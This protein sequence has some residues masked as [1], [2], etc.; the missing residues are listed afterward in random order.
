MRLV[1]E[2]LI[3]LNALLNLA[4]VSERIF[5]YQGKTGQRSGR[6]TQR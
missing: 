6:H 1:T 3:C 2:V 5:H 4:L